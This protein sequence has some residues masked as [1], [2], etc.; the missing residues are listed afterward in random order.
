MLSPEL[1]TWDSKCGAYSGQGHCSTPKQHSFLKQAGLKKEGSGF[2]EI[3]LCAENL[4]EKTKIF[5]V[6]LK[7]KVKKMIP[8]QTSKSSS[9]SCLK[10]FYMTLKHMSVKYVG[11]SNTTDEKS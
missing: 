2:G 9:L 10:N 6:N 11:K 8:G 1:G 7:G 3:I 4:G 5:T